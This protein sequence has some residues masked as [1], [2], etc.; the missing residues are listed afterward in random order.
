MR[1]HRTW[2]S[3]IQNKKLPRREKRSVRGCVDRRGVS[4]RNCIASRRTGRG[5]IKTEKRAARRDEVG[6]PCA[7]EKV[8]CLMARV[9]SQLDQ[10]VRNAK[11][12]GRKSGFTSIQWRTT[13]YPARSLKQEVRGRCASILSIRQTPL[14]VR[15]HA[16]PKPCIP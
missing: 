2:K 1:E 13:L 14:C 9:K 16:S 5:R 6:G 10:R 11:G 8:C 15:L 4:T 3:R 7:S 12:A